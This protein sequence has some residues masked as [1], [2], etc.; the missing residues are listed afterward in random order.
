M[1][2]IKAQIARE[3]YKA[4]KTLGGDGVLL[5]TIGSYGDT[6]DDDDVLILLRDWNAARPAP[7][8]AQKTQH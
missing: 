8:L 2:D 7:D 6:L 5:S 3:I 1:A 4:V